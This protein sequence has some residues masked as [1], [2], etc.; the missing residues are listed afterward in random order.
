MADLIGYPDALLNPYSQQWTFGVERQIVKGWVLSVDYVGSHTVKIARP[1]DVDPPS[2]FTRTAPGQFFNGAASAAIAAQAANCSRP[3]WVAFYASEGVTCNTASATPTLPQPLYSVITSDVNDGYLR[4][5]SLNVNLSHTFSSH[6]AALASYVYSHA[7]DNVDPDAT[8]Q[9]PNNPN[10]TGKAEE[11][12]ALFDQRH[13][14]VLSGTYSA[15]WGFHLGGIATLASG[16]PFN[17]TTGVTNSGDTGAT[18]DRPVINGAVVGRNIGRGRDIYDFSP[19][20]EKE[21]VFPG[22]RF[23]LRARSEAFNVF[24]HANFVG[25]NGVFGNGATPSNTLGQPLTGITNQLPARSLQFSLR[26][27]F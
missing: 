21:F 22:D 12:N 16:L 25:Y 19:F 4:Y 27:Q 8:G 5:N 26:F 17:Y 2:S 7:I 23:R 24:N 1:L 3:L 15:P 14:F 18:T 10:L 20:L 13:R 9:N 11:G 6:F